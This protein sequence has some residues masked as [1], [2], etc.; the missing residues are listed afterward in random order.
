MNWL[1]RIGIPLGVLVLILAVIPFFISVNDYIPQIEKAASE[2]LKEPVKIQKLR[3]A[4]LPLPHLTVDGI[5]V[6]K[7]EDLTVGKV[8]VTPDLWSLLG[9]SKV[10]R[11]I[12]IDKLV[13]TQGGLDKI[14]VWTTSDKPDE[15]PAVRVERIK[16][17]DALLKLAKSTFGPFDARLRMTASGALEEAS[18]VGRDGKL[19]AV[20]KPQEKDK[21][22]VEASA[23]SWQL[24][25]GP[26]VV[27]D[28]LNI[29]GVATTAEARLD[30]VHAKLY[31]GTVAGTIT[32]GYQKGLQLKGNLEVNQVELKSL[33]PLISPGTGMTGRL[34]ARPVFS[35]SA[36]N[37]DR[38]LNAL[39]LETA[40][41]I[42]NGVLHGV[43]IVKAA[44]SFIS[45]EGGKGGETHFDQLSG[46][47]VME[48]GTYRFTQLNI[49][50]GSLSAD[51]AVTISPKQELSGK[52][53][54][55][56]KAAKL[57]SASVP[58]NVSGT[59]HSPLLYPTGGTIAGAA[60]GTAIGGPLG[61]GVGAKVGQWA[62]GL[63][64]KKE[65]TKK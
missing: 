29:K 8:T 34:N 22:S 16:L 61:T 31:G 53:N 1:K 20:I 10:I 60:L 55:K 7:T 32:I 43:D 28:E 46:H 30:D 50:S 11:S 14:P 49:A 3:L 2:R 26:P 38:V 41:S 13:I 4:L 15:P 37:A 12:Q 23:K 39:H 48:R 5:T 54:A 17:D 21:Y 57:A 9:S 64:G 51:G 44:T 58:L 33:V 59:V 62:E 36:P 27:F 25:A 42:H 65:A 6:G 24:P 52:I 63:F 35:A 56:V 47:L 40:F 19:K 18:V 45:K